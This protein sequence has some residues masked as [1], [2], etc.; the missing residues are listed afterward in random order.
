MITFQQN[1]N[2]YIQCQVQCTCCV[3]VVLQNTC[4]PFEVGGLLCEGRVNCVIIHALQIL[5]LIVTPA[6]I[7]SCIYV[8]VLHC[9]YMYEHN[10]CIVSSNYLNVNTHQ[11]ETPN[12][13]LFKT[14][15]TKQNTHTNKKN[16]QYK[17][18]TKYK[19]QYKT[20]TKQNN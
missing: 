3:H 6:L 5:Q 13:K 14:K 12:I 7:H 19:T 2:I 15:Q 20:N 16:T 9:K 4:A 18:K 1:K 10:K 11:L 17:T 8:L